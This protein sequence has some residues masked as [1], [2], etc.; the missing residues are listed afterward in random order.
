MHCCGRR[1]QH[2]SCP[3]SDSQPLVNRRSI[4]ARRVPE[5]DLANGFANSSYGQSWTLLDSAAGRDPIRA[6]LTDNSGLIWTIGILLRIRRLALESLRACR[7][8]GTSDNWPGPRVRKPVGEGAGQSSRLKVRTP[9]GL[10]CVAGRTCIWPSAPSYWP[11]PPVMATRYGA[12]LPRRIS[13]WAVIRPP[14][15]K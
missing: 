14:R 15:K 13:A 2:A 7:V 10:V 6:G 3:A 12:G 9:L 4:R 8:S 1:E 11:V 5:A